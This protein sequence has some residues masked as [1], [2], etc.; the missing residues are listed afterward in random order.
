MCGRPSWLKDMWPAEL[1]TV[2]GVEF[3]H[4]LP[5]STPKL[6][7]KRLQIPSNRDHK[8]L[9]RGTLGGLGTACPLLLLC[10]RA[11]LCDLNSFR[12]L[13]PA[14]SLRGGGGRCV[15]IWGT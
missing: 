9:N 1:D 15:Q 4:L 10:C 6:L 2:S 5:T 14:K 7:C 13:A 8:A 3:E 12:L 11:F